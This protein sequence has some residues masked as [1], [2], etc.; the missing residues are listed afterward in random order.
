ME[1][2]ETTSQASESA[3]ERAQRFAKIIGTMVQS[4]RA[5]FGLRP[6]GASMAGN[7]ELKPMEGESL[8]AW[9]Y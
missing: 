9:H 6:A 2:L 8:N 4:V 3:H 5:R 1:K 7:P